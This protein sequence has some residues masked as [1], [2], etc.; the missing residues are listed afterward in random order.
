MA[1][2][3]SEGLFSRELRGATIDVALGDITKLG[4]R[5]DRQRGK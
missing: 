1:Q 4:G 5:R 2:T 3:V